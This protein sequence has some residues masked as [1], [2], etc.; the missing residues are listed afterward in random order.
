MGQLARA[1]AVACA[2]A[3]SVWL[4]TTSEKEQTTTN[5]NNNNNNRNNNSNK[6]ELPGCKGRKISQGRPPDRE[7]LSAACLNPQVSSGQFENTPAS[8]G[9]KL[10]GVSVLQRHLDRWLYK[11]RLIGNVCWPGQL[12]SSVESSQLAAE[13]CYSEL[14]SV[15]QEWPRQP[16]PYARPLYGSCSVWGDSHQ[17]PPQATKQGRQHASFWGD[18]LKTQY[19]DRWKLVSPTC[20]LGDIALHCDK[21][22]KNE[23]TLQT[24]Y[25]SICGRL[26]SSLEYAPE[27]TIVGYVT[28]PMRGTP[29][30]VQSAQCSGTRLAELT[31]EAE[32]AHQADVEWNA[33][34]RATASRLANASGRTAAPGSPCDAA[35]FL[36]SL[37]D[38]TIVHACTGLPDVPPSL[39]NSRTS[40]PEDQDG[41]LFSQVNQD[42]TSSRVY[43]LNYFRRTNQSAFVEYASLYYGYYL[44]AIR[45]RLSLAAL[46]EG[47]VL[48][49]DVMSDSNISPL[50]AIYQLDEAMKVRPPYLSALVHELFRNESG[51]ELFVR[52]LYNGQVQQVCPGRISSSECPWAEWSQLVA[53]FTPSKESCPQFYT[54]FDWSGG[55][56]QRSFSDDMT[57]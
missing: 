52:V 35:S 34:I 47:P 22:Q 18:M 38:C 3:L 54:D 39:L 24:V 36:D 51:R 50:L 49:V 30:Y 16:D 44:A 41:S 13:Q 28:E 4:A 29:W 7:L 57:R 15:W 9:L 19:V 27:A 32:K 25:K 56:Y 5:N 53:K 46:R 45:H 42:E 6:G 21:A 11:H 23:I 2:V 14:N 1:G 55:K 12:N 20:T 40:L 33:R 8:P 31:A 43:N 26:P 10:V 37:I 17:G 48:T